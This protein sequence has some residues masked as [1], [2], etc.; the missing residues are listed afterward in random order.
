MFFVLYMALPS[1]NAGETSVKSS[2]GKN[3]T[4]LKEYFGM[5][6][7][8]ESAYALSHEQKLGFCDVCMKGDTLS[9]TALNEAG[10]DDIIGRCL[11]IGFVGVVHKCIVVWRGHV[12]LR[13][14]GIV[15]GHVW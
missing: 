13:V 11:G 12:S 15:C 4:K 5:A 14:V 10:K 7:L 9:I 6:N 1:T 8:C 3:V 2:F